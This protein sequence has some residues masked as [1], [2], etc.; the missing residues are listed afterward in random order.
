MLRCI[1]GLL[2]V[3]AA[4]AGLA[5]VAAET[6][7]AMPYRIGVLE[8]LP[9]ARNT[10]NLDAFRQGMREL[11][12]G[13]GNDFELLYRSADGRSERFPDLAK[14]LVSL[15]VNV[16]VTRG[17]PAALAAKRATTTIPIVMSP[18]GD[19]LLSGL[20]ASFA[21]PGGNVTGLSTNLI[22]LAAK[23]L[24]LLRQ[25]VPGVLRIAA[26]MNTS[27][28]AIALEW[29][30]LEATAQRTRIE[31]QLLDVR[32]P[33]DLR[34]AF[35]TGIR[36]RVGAVIVGI[37]DLTQMHQREIIGHAAKTRLPAMYASREFASAGGLI[38]YGVSYPDLYRRAAKFVDRILKG[39]RP[40]DLAIEQPA[41]F[42]LTINLK[43]ARSLGLTMPPSL[44]LRANQIIE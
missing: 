38:S 33:D 18:S 2:L 12:Y 1:T 25:V 36:Q 21:R 39:A 43:T 20:V 15:K 42:D 37:D 30:E 3:V 41:A 34:R 17:T 5:T 23:R 11:G 14:E 24:E 44:L 31:L 4:N 8:R 32:Q 6:Q 10:E 40:A 35:E 29:K 22:D 13:E 7:P 27:N 19:P 26:I 16:I 9:A 28:P